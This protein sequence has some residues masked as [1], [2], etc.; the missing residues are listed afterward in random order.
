MCLYVSDNTRD[1]TFYSIIDEDHTM[2]DDTEDTDSK[3]TD[4]NLTEDC[5]G[6]ESVESITK[7][8]RVRK[9][10]P[11]NRSSESS[12]L[13]PSGTKEENERKKPKIT[14]SFVIP[15]AKHIRFDNIES[16]ENNIAKHIVQETSANE[17]YVS[18]TPSKD[19]STLLSLGQSS[20][21]ITFVNKK[22]YDVKVDTASNKNLNKIEEDTSLEDKLSEETDK[23]AQY[24]KNFNLDIE[25]VK[26]CP[27][28]TRKPQV[29]DIIAFKVC[30]AYNCVLN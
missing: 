5:N 3:V 16:K 1:V 9:R 11:K 27:S 22:K 13:L 15:T 18:R 17:S 19:L 6:T 10:R 24:S 7:R 14:D 12:F 29:K 20:T 21:P 28:M 8:K 26:L 30:T 23:K 4:N 2:L 25:K